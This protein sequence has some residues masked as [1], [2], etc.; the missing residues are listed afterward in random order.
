MAHA[1]QSHLHAVAITFVLGFGLICQAMI[2]W[3]LRACGC[4][5]DW[6]QT[7]FDD[8]WDDEDVCC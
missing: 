7:P 8:Y 4:Y 1:C 6:G 5:N 3:L 2:L